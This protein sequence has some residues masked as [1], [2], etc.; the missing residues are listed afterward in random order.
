METNLATDKRPHNEDLATYLDK[1]LRQDYRHLPQVP[2]RPSWE[3]TPDV[4][5]SSRPEVPP[6]T[7]NAPSENTTTPTAKPREARPSKPGVDQTNRPS[8]R[9]VRSKRGKVRRKKTDKPRNTR[10]TVMAILIPVLAV[11]LLVL[12]RKPGNTPASMASP[13]LDTGMMTLDQTDPEVTIDWKVPPAYKAAGRDPM[14]WVPAP[15]VNQDNPKRPVN[16]RRNLVVKGILYSQDRPAVV[17]GTSLL[18]EGDEIS[19][20]T[21]VKI[22]RDT[23]EFQADGQTWKQ[24]V[25]PTD[26]GSK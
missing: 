7:D 18:H 10:Q 2:S 4:P 5:R 3:H 12:M 14:A 23:I 8:K 15:I 13:G 25:T 11:A 17:I 21:I 22:E 26:T 1:L 16:T 20:A 6:P 19:G 24:P 9:T